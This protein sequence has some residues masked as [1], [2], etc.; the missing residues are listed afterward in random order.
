[1]VF[2][3]ETPSIARIRFQI[4]TLNGVW[5][6]VPV[7]GRNASPAKLDA[8]ESTRPFRGIIFKPVCECKAQTAAI[9]IPMMFLNCDYSCNG[10]IGDRR[11]GVVLT[12]FPDRSLLLA[13]NSVS[14]SAT[15]A[16]RGH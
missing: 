1:M 4:C 9:S 5:P 8:L 2:G 11:S 10:S 12:V 14:L 7:K 15:S 13:G 6:N 16:K 3:G